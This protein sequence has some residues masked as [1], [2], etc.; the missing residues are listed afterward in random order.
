MNETVVAVCV[1]FARYS[2][3]R[4]LEY[5]GLRLPSIPLTLPLLFDDCHSTNLF[6]PLTKLAFLCSKS[7]TPANYIVN[8]LNYLIQIYITLHGLMFA[9]ILCHLMVENVD[10][11]G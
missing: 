6:L 10:L 4:F 9:V 8:A 5:D 3:I 1:W 2:F 7:K 11:L